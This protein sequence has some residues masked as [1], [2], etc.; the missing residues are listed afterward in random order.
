MSMLRQDPLTGRWVIVA[1]GRDERPNE[2]LALSRAD[3]PLADC[4]FCPGHED[5]TTPEVQVLGRPDGSPPNTPGWRLR[6]FP[7]M[8]PALVPADP[9]PVFGLDE[10][11]SPTLHRHAAGIGH[12]EVVVYTTDHHAGPASLTAAQHEELLRVLRDRGRVFARHPQVRYIS[13]F[14]NHGPEAGATLSHPHMQII[15]APEVPLLAAEKAARCA[16][17]RQEHQRCLV[18]DVEAAERAGGARLIAGNDL[19]TAFAPWASRFPW[20]MLFVPRRHGSSLLQA[21]DAELAALAEVL[22]PAL[23]CLARRHGEPSLNLVFHNAAVDTEGR[24]VGADSYHWHLEVLPRLGR[25]AGFEVGTGYT[26]NA[27]VPEEAARWMRQE[28]E[29]A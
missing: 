29:Q 24:D 23:R 4:P 19:W 21:T 2:Y 7:N 17:Y 16:A 25:P 11:P 5:Q 6:A 22:A 12:H 9:P 26:I 13:P 27:V 3:M 1:A 10:I 14:C 20:E 28:W 18:C 8:Y 15:G